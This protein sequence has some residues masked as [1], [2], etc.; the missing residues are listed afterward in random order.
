MLKIISS[1]CENDFEEKK[2]QAKNWFMPNPTWLFYT[3]LLPF[4]LICV[5]DALVAFSFCDFS[6]KFRVA[7]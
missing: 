1:T 7:Y 5:G 2:L 3:P 4:F 6:W